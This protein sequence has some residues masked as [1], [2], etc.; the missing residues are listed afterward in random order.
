MTSP[1]T[2]TLPRSSV[3]TSS[4]PKIPSP[5]SSPPS[6]CSPPV[7][8]CVGSIVFGHIGDRAGRKAA[9][10]LS[11]LAMAIPTLLIGLLPTF[12]QIGLAAPALLV[13]LRLVQGLSVGG[14][15][16][17]SITFLVER[18][19][20][21]RRGFFGGWSVVG[22][23]GGILLG[24]AVGA[25]VTTVLGAA[26]TAA[27]GWRVPFLLGIPVGLPGFSLPRPLIEARLAPADPPPHLPVIEAFR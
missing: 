21:E 25:V 22:A 23:T 17:T 20:P 7:F 27:W 15:Y 13:L 16:G 4:Q 18:A 5:R 24:S 1:F 11:V 12:A 9:L 8:S 10:T 26:E 3:A 19:S 6:E 14:E 2:A